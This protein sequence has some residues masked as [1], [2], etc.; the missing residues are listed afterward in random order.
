MRLFVENCL[1]MK[2]IRGWKLQMYQFNC[3]PSLLNSDDLT[4]QEVWSLGI[5]H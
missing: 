2:V 5:C 1:Q 4:F 3:R